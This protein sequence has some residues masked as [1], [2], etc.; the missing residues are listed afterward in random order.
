M[1]K[2]LAIFLL[3][4]LIA[5]CSPQDDSQKKS[6]SSDSAT[7]STT[8]TPDAAPGD[9]TFSFSAASLTPGC[10]SESKM[11]C[12]INLMLKCTINPNFAECASNKKSM[13]KFIF[14][15]DDSLDRPTEI[16]YQVS[17]IKPRSDGTVE[18]HTQSTCNGNW[19]G[20]CNGNIIYVMEP[21]NDNW[22]VNNL[23]SV[24]TK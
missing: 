10:D 4:S 2:F 19:F 14:M 22:I 3:S 5:A 12:A 13:P 15:V 24:E 16:T 11:V 6:N 8:A 23:Y 18:V 9:E 17:K 7:L 1:P 21:Q 20:E